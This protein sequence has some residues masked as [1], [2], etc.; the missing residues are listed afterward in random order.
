MCLLGTCAG[1]VTNLLMIF[2]GLKASRLLGVQVDPYGLYVA[3][4]HASQSPAACTAA[5][6]R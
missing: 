3:Q 1:V 5:W 2:D 4:S 6:P